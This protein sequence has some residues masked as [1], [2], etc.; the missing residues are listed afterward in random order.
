MAPRTRF[1]SDHSRC[2]VSATQSCTVLRAQVTN[3]TRLLADPH[4]TISLERSG[5]PDI[6]SLE[7]LVDE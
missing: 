4:E 5:Y 1:S 6:V 3:A 2:C 7:Q